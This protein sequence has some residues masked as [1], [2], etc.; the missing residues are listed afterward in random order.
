[1]GCCGVKEIPA[2]ASK[3]ARR[4]ALAHK[5]CARHRRHRRL[6]RLRRHRRH[7]RMT[8]V[9]SDDQCRSVPPGVARDSVHDVSQCTP[10]RSLLGSDTCPCTDARLHA[11]AVVVARA[12]AFTRAQPEF[13]CTGKPRTIRTH[14]TR[15]PNLWVVAYTR[16]TRLHPLLTSCVRQTAGTRQSRGRWQSRLADGP[17][18]RL[19][20]PCNSSQRHHCRWHRARRWTYRQRLALATTLR[21]SIPIRRRRHPSTSQRLSRWTAQPRAPCLRVVQTC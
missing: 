17:R 15:R 2:P 11:R 6:R 3:P 20:S 7:R 4:P 18:Q 10:L 12:L 1:M 9:L 21:G 14:G 8:Y 19:R 16:I 13:A 5:C